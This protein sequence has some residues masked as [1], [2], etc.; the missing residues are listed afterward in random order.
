MAAKKSRS[1]TRKPVGRAKA[2][3]KTSRRTNRKALRT[4]GPLD[5]M[6]PWS[7]T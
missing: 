7:I 3:K 1:K 5:P 2:T 4:K 6:T